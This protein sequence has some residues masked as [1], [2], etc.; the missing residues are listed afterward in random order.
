[1]TDDLDDVLDGQGDDLADLLDDLHDGL[2]ELLDNLHD[3]DDLLDSLDSA[4]KES[5]RSKP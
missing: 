4:P 2:A 3:L 5:V 1:M